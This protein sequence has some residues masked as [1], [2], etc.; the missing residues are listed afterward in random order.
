MGGAQPI[1]GPNHWEIVLSIPIGGKGPWY[2]H[3]AEY[4]INSVRDTVLLKGLTCVTSFNM[5][6]D[7]QRSNVISLSQERRERQRRDVIDEIKGIARQ[8]L[9]V[10]GPASLSLSRIA[11]AM[12]WTT[13]ALYRYFPN[14]DALITSLI[15]DAFQALGKDTEEALKHVPQDNIETRYMAFVRSYRRWA[16]SHPQDYVLM[17]GSAYPGYK[18]P[19]GQIMEASMGS[20]QPFVELLQY[21]QAVGR[22]QIPRSYLEGAASILH[23]IDP[24]EIKAIHSEL[25]SYLVTLAYLVWLQIHGLVWEE[26][27]GHL[28]SALFEDG[29][30]YD[31]QARATG[32]MYGLIPLHGPPF[33]T[34]PK[35]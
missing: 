2:R 21:A 15:L 27:S 11:R 6:G 14:R 18:A 29:R 12:G 4:L 25:P 22:L 17:H 10:D 5:K 33:V 3:T 13:P 34:L 16:L 26:I 24:L 23:D 8:Q 31:I 7:T 28:P 20:L 32:Q 9:A 35:S 30:L 1:L 19:I